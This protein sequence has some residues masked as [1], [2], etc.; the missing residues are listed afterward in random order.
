VARTE[1]N[2]AYREAEH[3]RLQGLPFVVGYEVRRSNRV[4]T[5]DIC[6]PLAGNYPKDF[7]FV[8]WH[9]NCRCSVIP[10]LATAGELSQL[11]D[12]ILSGKSTDAFTSKNQIADVSDG[13]KNWVS[14]NKDMLLRVK[15]VPYFL[16]DNS[17]LSELDFLKQRNSK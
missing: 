15:S 14:E 10:I 4:F 3:L 5:C 11:N 17:H 12:L 2:Q 9:Q 1:T 13:F 6:G 16:T 8:G 7:K